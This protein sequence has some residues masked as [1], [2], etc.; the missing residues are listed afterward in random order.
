MYESNRIDVIMKLL[1]NIRLS[2]FIRNFNRLNKNITLNVSNV[3]KDYILR[4][5]FRITS[6]SGLIRRI[7]SVVR[8]NQGTNERNEAR[9]SLLST[10]FLSSLRSES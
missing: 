9:F 5:L 4:S 2:L 1:H 8:T 6:I 10:C 3:R 7:Y